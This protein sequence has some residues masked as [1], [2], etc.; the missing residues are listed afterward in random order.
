MCAAQDVV[1]INTEHKGLSV[2]LL[3]SASLLGMMHLYRFGFVVGIL[4]VNERPTTLPTTP[5]LDDPDAHFVTLQQSILMSEHSFSMIT[6][7]KTKVKGG[8]LTSMFGYGNVVGGVWLQRL[9]WVAFRLS[10]SGAA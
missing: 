2:R 9:C 5:L 4:Q 1:G 6:I 7:E 8:L 3:R 10:M